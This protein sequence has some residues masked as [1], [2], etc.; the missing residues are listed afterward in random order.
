MLFECCK[1]AQ[2]Y[3]L[4]GLVLYYGFVPEELKRQLLV[5]TPFPGSHKCSVSNTNFK[6]FNMAN[7]KIVFCSLVF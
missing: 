5:M 1:I 4:H 2:G 6:V 7:L 3:S